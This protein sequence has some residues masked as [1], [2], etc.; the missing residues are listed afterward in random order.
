MSQ[1]ATDGQDMGQDLGQDLP[2][3][4]VEMAWKTLYAQDTV[5]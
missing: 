2:Q 4:G 5:L 1:L 3:P